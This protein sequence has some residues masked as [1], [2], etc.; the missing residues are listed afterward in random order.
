[1]GNKFAD[2]VKFSA[3]GTSAATITTGV[4]AAKCRNLT[5][6]ISDG[7]FSVGDTN[8]P[9][10]VEDA[11]GNWESGLYAISSTTTLTRTQINASSN[12]G[13]AVTFDGGALTVFNVNS[14]AILNSAANPNDPG[15]D[16]IICAGQ[17]NMQGQMSPDATIDVTDPRVYAWGGCPTDSSYQK[18][19]LATE[20]LK[21]Y[22]IAP[23]MGPA[24]WFGKTYAG[25]IPG[26]RKVLLVPVAKG[27]TYLVAQ[28]AEWS[29]GDGTSNGLVASGY[30]Y[31]NAILQ[32]NAALAAAQVLYP[33]SRIVGT[34]WLQGES[35][36]A[37]TVSQ[38]RYASA[39]KA[40]IQGFRNRMTGAQNSWFLIAGMIGE[41][42]ANVDGTTAAYGPIDLA[43]QQ[44]AAEVSRCAYVAGVSGY[45]FS[46]SNKVHYNTT[47]ARIMGCGLS[48]VLGKALT[49]RGTDST[50]PTILSAAVYN[51]SPNTIAATLSEPF[52]P[53]YP[54][55][56]SAYTISSGHTVTAATGSGNVLYLTVT[57][58]FINGEAARTLT[59]TA[60]GNGIRDFSGNMMTSQ[61]G[62][63]ITNSVA[64][65]DN[66]PP[67]LSGATVANASPSSLT[68][69]ASETLDTTYT[70]A[71]SAFTVSGHT[72][73]SVTVNSGSI[74]LGLGEPFV[75]GEAAR[76]V[77]YTQPATNGFRDLVG[78]LAIT[79]TGLTVTNNV[80]SADTTPPTFVSAQ[81]ANAT[82]TVVQ[83]TM[84]E[85]LAA[86]NPPS[87]AFTI[88]E[89][90]TSK[91]ISSASV[92]GTIVS[93][94]CSSAFS[95]GTTI[96][97]TYTDPGTDPRI[98]D[99]SNNPAATFTAQPVT[100]NVAAA[101]NT[102]VRFTGMTNM[103]ETSTTPPYAYAENSTYTN[104]TTAVNGAVSSLALAGDGMIMMQLGNVSTQPM[105]GFR[106]T[107]TVGNYASVPYD[108]MAKTT[109]YS[110]YQGT[111]TTAVSN[112]IPANSDWVKFVRSGT[113]IACYVSSDNQVSWTLI[114]TWTG[115]VTGTLYC[116]IM[117]IYTSASVYSTFTAPQGTGWA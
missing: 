38:I 19:A 27:A 60:P 73:T 28:T 115:V 69:T 31:E 87:S 47:G 26:N 11:T 23:G 35:D 97:V 107:A 48:T 5:K 70:P 68:M 105:V 15:F 72:V 62:V 3:T 10:M 9:F 59:F 79:F 43:H 50:A 64:A 108:M 71:T 58:S 114:F 86:S 65:V 94:T 83:I 54:P 18:I 1:M 75:N 78:N 56:A 103:T 30:L 100:N 112:R 12:A 17:S 63:S 6:A 40:L 93:V 16:I 99:P 91:T 34:I 82:P 74:V 51:A 96:L 55:V 113:T 49:Y 106:T 8:V 52:D 76:S 33:S 42:V 92:S 95:N 25:M 53:A 21:H 98:K 2:R 37:Y 102:P 14:S 45:Q 104:Y 24:T 84:S 67:T 89:S 32:A 13:R 7:D 81:V 4:A 111:A 117:G 101:G 36:A 41:Y 29:P 90:G 77:S 20:P 88:T 85:T 80:A 61:S 66:T 39:L 44:V 116:Q 22:T 46:P 110:A 109:G 57:P